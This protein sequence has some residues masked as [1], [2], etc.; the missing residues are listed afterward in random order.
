MLLRRL[1]AKQRTCGPKAHVHDSHRNGELGRS[2]GIA[3]QAAT[4]A[5][6]ACPHACNDGSGPAVG[7]THHGHYLG[8]EMTTSRSEPGSQPTQEYHGGNT[9]RRHQQ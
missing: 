3:K 2:E 1:A 7:C 6:R 4:Y 9:S 5:S 8:L